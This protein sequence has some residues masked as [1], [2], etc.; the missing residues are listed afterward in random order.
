MCSTSGIIFGLRAMRES[1]VVGKRVLEVGALD[2]NGGLRSVLVA[3][4][5]SEYIGVDL[6]A[7]PG[8]DVTCDVSKLV[9]SFGEESFD[10]VVNTE[11]LEH[12]EHW[13][14]AISNL[15]RV[16]RPGGVMVTTTRSPGFKYHGYPYD[17]WRFRP[18][19]MRH[20]FCDFEILDLIPDPDAPGI[21]LKARKPELFEENNLDDVELYSIITNRFE[22]SVDAESIT[23]VQRN[24][25]WRNRIRRAIIRPIDWV[26]KTIF[27]YQG[28]TNLDDVELYSIITNRFENSVDAES[29]RKPK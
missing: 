4:G 24:Y 7:G 2:F 18:E 20:I 3:Y 29:A 6:Q 19:D 27:S 25:L 26:L 9:E 17:F 5:P 1:E 15:K 22:N 28:E 10:I 11:L 14:S 8:V 16:L 23:R 12:V 13:R 21:F